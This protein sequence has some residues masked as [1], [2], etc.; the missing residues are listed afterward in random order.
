MVLLIS[1]GFSVR[2]YSIE[3]GRLVIQRPFFSK[4][5][6]LGQDLSVTSDPEAGKGA[7]KVSGNGGLFGYYGSFRSKKLGLFTAYATD[8]KFGVV[9]KTGGK[10]YVVTPDEPEMFMTRLTESAG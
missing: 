3:Y 8:W 6:Q 4:S 2:G 5:I 9:V 7:V 10:T 1:W